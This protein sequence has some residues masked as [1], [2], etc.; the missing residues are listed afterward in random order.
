MIW[1]L[2]RYLA[3]CRHEFTGRETFCELFGPL[4][5]LEEEWRKQGATEKEIAVTAFDWDYVLKTEPAANCAAISGLDTTVL[6]DNPEYTVCRDGL[7]RTVKL[8][9]SATIQLPLDHPVKTMD[10]WLKIKHWY[11]FREERVNREELMQQKALREKGYLTLFNILGGFDQ[12][13]QLLGEE[14]LCIAFYDEPEMVRDMLD[15]FMDT[16]VKVL[17]RIGDIVPID[18]LMIHED[19][20]GKSGSLIEPNLIREFLKIY[21][22]TVWDCVRS[23][24]AQIFSQDSD[25]DMNSVLDTF[26]ECG[27][28]CTYPCE[29]AAGMDMVALKKKY[30]RK[31]F[32]KGGIDKFALLKGKEAI[33]K[34]LE[35]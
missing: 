23:F 16:A 6:E 5:P 17:E 21:Y 18:N 9:K 24:G 35:Y 13:R 19:M 4:A 28:N 15:T 2:E 25:G 34:E 30:G 14:G 11:T 32:Y 27:I 29:P 12:P 26:V 10:D 31:L 8:I 3:R 33:R 20:A 7:G 22:N 1:D